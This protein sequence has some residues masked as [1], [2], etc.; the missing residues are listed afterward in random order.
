[1]IEP[2]ELMK[3]VLKKYEEKG[4]QKYPGGFRS[5][6]RGKRIIVEMGR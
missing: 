6:K 3:K 4:M 1:M 2:N 5:F